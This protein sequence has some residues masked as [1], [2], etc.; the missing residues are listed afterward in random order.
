MPHGH[1]FFWTPDIIWTHV[2]SDAIVTLAY[3]LIPA[4]LF[5]F[6]R[7]RPSLPF[8]WV[9][10]LFGIFIL[11]CGTTHLMGIITLWH[12]V[13]RLE[14]LVKAATAAASLGT[15]IALLPMIPQA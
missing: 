15:A 2:V 11:A 4:F 10:W 3:Y 9:F 14:G 8:P 5:F 6:V 7:K 1:C 13:Y 12:P